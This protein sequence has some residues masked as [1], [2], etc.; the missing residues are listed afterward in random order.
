[1]TPQF[2]L[3]RQ[4][5]WLAESARSFVEC[6]ACGDRFSWDGD[7]NELAEEALQRG[8]RA[9]EFTSALCPNHAK[10]MQQVGE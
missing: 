6:D 5:Q 7:A 4:K 3:V 10:K 9:D 2:C 8:W 1:M